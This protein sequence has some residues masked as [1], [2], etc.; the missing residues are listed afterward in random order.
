MPG[1]RK[2][3]ILIIACD[4]LPYIHILLCYFFS[5]IGLSVPGL[6]PV[7]GTVDHVTPAVKY[8]HLEIFS[9]QSHSDRAEEIVQ[10]VTVGSKCIGDIDG[11]IFQYTNRNFCGV[12]ASIGI[13]GYMRDYK[14][15]GVGIR[16]GWILLAR[17]A[18]AL[19]SE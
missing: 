13:A 10:S 19:I 8:P 12:A 6:I 15:A 18:V 1:E 3:A 5:P 7:G 9:L 16:K 14:S 17:S 11:V 4:D 2:L